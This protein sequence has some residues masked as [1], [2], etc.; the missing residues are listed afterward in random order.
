M[1]VVNTFLMFYSFWFT[2][3]ALALGLIL[4]WLDPS[5]ASLPA[6]SL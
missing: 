2:R 5:T 3:I 6:S 4:D 1:S